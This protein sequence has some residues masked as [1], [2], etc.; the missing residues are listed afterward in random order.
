MNTE[1]QGAHRRDKRKPGHSLQAGLP[2]R[3]RPQPLAFSRPR[4]TGA[5]GM[6]PGLGP[7]AFREDTALTHFPK[8]ASTKFDIRSA[9]WSIWTLR[10]PRQVLVV[11]APA[12]QKAKLWGAGIL[13]G[14]VHL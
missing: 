4:E 1:G 10:T 6:L 12:R 2:H 5:P 8:K 9:S 7:L 14:R 11:V 13:D 3:A